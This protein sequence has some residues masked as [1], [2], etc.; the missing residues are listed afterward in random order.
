MATN[1]VAPGGPAAAV[2]AAFGLQFDQ[3][4][5][6]P[7]AA[8]PTGDRLDRRP[9]VVQPGQETHLRV[10]DFGTDKY[11]LNAYIF[12]S[13]NDATTNYDKVLFSRGKNA[14]DAVATLGRARRPTSR[15]RSSA[16]RSTA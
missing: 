13:T 14:A 16:A 2:H 4:S 7:F 1:Y 15:S 10:L 12:D 5:R 6:P 9:G 11:G 3:V 8:A